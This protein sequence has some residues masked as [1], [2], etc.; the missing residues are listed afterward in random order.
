MDT[1][2]TDPENGPS[3]DKKGGTEMRIEGSP[4]NKNKIINRLTRLTGKRAVYNG[5]PEFSYTIGGYTVYRDGS[6]MVLVEDADR[7]VLNTL[8]KEKLLKR[9]EEQAKKLG[10]SID[11]AP[12]ADK[13]PVN[14][15]IPAEV[16]AVETEDDPIE[17]DG[18]PEDTIEANDA[19]VPPI[20]EPPAD[21]SPQRPFVLDGA[22]D[23][24]G[25]E[26]PINPAEPQPFHTDAFGYKVYDTPITIRHGFI[27]VKTMVNLLNMIYSKG[28]LI[29]RSTNRPMAFSVAESVISELSFE[30]NLTFARFKSILRASD[31]AGLVRGIVFT[32][33]SVSFTGFPKTSDFVV[34]KAYETLAEAM[35]RYADERKW[36]AARKET[37][38][39]EKYSF[40]IWLNHIGITGPE[41]K[42]YRSVLM[43]N[44]SGISSF[45]TRTQQDA[46]NSRRN[47]EAEARRRERE[48]RTG[49]SRKD[50]AAVNF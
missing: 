44:L 21:T 38:D 25:S 32:E 5:A 46:F 24:A 47:A 29:N 4:Q 41:N 6:V 7:E 34:R 37:Y 13:P 28:D 27:S 15:D 17:E 23:P 18:E 20:P 10:L 48:R 45:R 35:F 26:V 42:T 8:F 33:N 11:V 3:S 2:E 9:D 1:A 39:N 14:A 36:V 30:R 16:S 40:R 43:R 31:R 22:I 50:F 49:E 12:I 19:D